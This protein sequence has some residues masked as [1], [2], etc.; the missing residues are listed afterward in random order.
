VK[1]IILNILTLDF[2]LL[3][4][5]VRLINSPEYDRTMSDRGGRRAV[6]SGNTVNDVCHAEARR[7]ASEHG[8]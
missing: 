1:P 8:H 6:S 4:I 5:Y 7:Q 3:C 2:E